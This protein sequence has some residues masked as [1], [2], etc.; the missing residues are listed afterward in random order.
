MT[1]EEQTISGLLFGTFP[2]Q[3]L[4]RGNATINWSGRKFKRNGEFSDIK[5]ES[6]FIVRISR[7]SFIFYFVQLELFNP[8]KF[9]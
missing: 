9:I 8:F 7:V 6:V 5:T 3:K 2:S 1:D 4:I